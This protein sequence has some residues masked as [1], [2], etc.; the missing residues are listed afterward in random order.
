MALYGHPGGLIIQR[1]YGLNLIA[2]SCLLN[3]V[4][5]AGKRCCLLPFWG[6]IVMVIGEWGCTM[7]KDGNG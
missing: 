7:C 2:Y 1:D 3:R 4:F 5:L 6:I